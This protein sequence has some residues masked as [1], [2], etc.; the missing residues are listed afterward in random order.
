MP[1]WSRKEREQDLDRELRDHLE[2]ETAEQEEGGLSAEEAR[3]AAQRAFVN[4]TLVKE[5]IREMTGWSSLENIWQDLRFAARVLRKNPVFAAAAILTLAL[6]IG[7]NTA[8]FSIV[9]SVLLR[10]RPY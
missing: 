7:A 6:G 4:T 2:L 8:I 10:P 3:Y 9:N 5:Q 1:W